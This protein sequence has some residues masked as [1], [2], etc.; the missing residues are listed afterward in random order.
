MK[1]IL[2]VPVIA[3]L[4]GT[5]LGT[6]LAMSLTVQPAA[7]AQKDVVCSKK[8]GACAHSGPATDF[9]CSLPCADSS[10][11]GNLVGTFGITKAETIAVSGTG[12]PNQACAPHV[13]AK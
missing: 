12:G 4:A 8:S 9:G 11:A 3:V 2:L 5:L 10:S 6:T 13:C 1:A 7:G